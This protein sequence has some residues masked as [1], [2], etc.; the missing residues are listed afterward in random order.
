[1]RV[2]AGRLALLVACLVLVALVAGCGNFGVEVSTPLPP[3]GIRGSVVLGPTCPNPPSV[4]P[5]GQVPCLTP[6][7]AQLVV[8]DSEGKVVTRVTSAAGDGTFAVDVPPGDYVVAPATN[9]S[10]PIAQPVSVQVVAGNY[11]EVQINYD[12]GLR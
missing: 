5:S 12:T 8:L 4:G 1:M 3:S 10:Y 9:D 7:A 2:G 6:Y 11:A